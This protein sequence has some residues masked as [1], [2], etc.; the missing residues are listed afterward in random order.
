MAILKDR[1]D[2][3]WSDGVSLVEGAA[4]AELFWTDGN[5]NKIFQTRVHIL[6]V[7]CVKR[8]AKS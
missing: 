3:V 2:L 1:L 6:Y 4:Y 5:A 7:R 8:N